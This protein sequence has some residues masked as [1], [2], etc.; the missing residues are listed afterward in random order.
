MFNFGDLQNVPMVSSWVV[1]VVLIIILI[2]AMK[3]AKKWL[4]RLAIVGLVAVTGFSFYA[5]TFSEVP[6][7]HDLKAKQQIIKDVFNDVKEE[8]KSEK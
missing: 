8:I 7:V 1:L 5:S 6:A 4:I 3:Q 2:G